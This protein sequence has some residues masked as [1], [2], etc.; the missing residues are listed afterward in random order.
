[1]SESPAIARARR[2]SG[3]VRHRFVCMKE[4][5]PDVRV[6]FS[7]IES[8]CEIERSERT[9]R[10]IEARL[11]NRPRPTD[12]DGAMGWDACAESQRLGRTRKG[13]DNG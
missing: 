5:N 12:R 4:V 11:E 3:P 13:V 2:R 10:G 8:Q 7:Q 9:M 1:M 6:S